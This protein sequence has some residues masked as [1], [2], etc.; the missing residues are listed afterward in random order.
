[1]SSQ[2][3]GRKDNDKIGVWATAGGGVYSAG[4][5]KVDFEDPFLNWILSYFDASLETKEIVGIFPVV[6]GLR[7][8]AG[9]Y[10]DV[11]IGSGVE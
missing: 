11:D 3:E 2:A 1:M 10:R 4:E 9:A 6:D 5:Q 8:D 7:S